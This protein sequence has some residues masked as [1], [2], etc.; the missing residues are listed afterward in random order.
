MRVVTS[1][2]TSWNNSVSDVGSIGM[3][4]CINYSVKS[5]EENTNSSTHAALLHNK[6][7]SNIDA[8]GDS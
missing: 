3:Q 7:T 2:I 4:L 1:V 5:D 8:H 6:G